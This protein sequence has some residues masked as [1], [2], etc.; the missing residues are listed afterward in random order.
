MPLLIAAGIV[1]GA[2]LGTSVTSSIVAFATDTPKSTGNPLKHARNLLFKPR[3]EG[4]QR[5]VGAAVVHDLFMLVGPHVYIR[6][7]L[8]R[9]LVMLAERGLRPCARH[10]PPFLDSGRLQAGRAS[11]SGRRPAPKHFILRKE[12]EPP[13]PPPEIQMPTLKAGHPYLFVVIKP[14]GDEYTFRFGWRGRESEQPCRND[15]EAEWVCSASDVPPQDFHP[16]VAL[17]GEPGTLWLMV[18]QMPLGWGE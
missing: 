15:Q 6:T 14:T 11:S 1:H 8:Q 13:P 10:G 7:R 2:N 12:N 18:F 3:G 9:R 4:F 16:T 5:A 17:S